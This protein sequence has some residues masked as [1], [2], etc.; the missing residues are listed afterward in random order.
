MPTIEQIRAA[1]ALL[2]W[3][4]HELADKA[5]LSQTGIARI[6]NG[7]NK[8]NSKTL[9]KIRSAF[10]EADIDF[11][12]DSGVKKRTGEVRILK[13]QEGFRSL[14]DDIYETASTLGGDI[15]LFNGTPSNF[16]QQLGEDWYNMHS[17]RM[18]ALKTDFTLKIIVKEGDQLLIASD[19]AEYKW[20]PEGLF[21]DKVFYSYGKKLALMNLDETPYISVIEQQDFAES[22]KVLFNIAWQHV[23]I[24]PPKN[25]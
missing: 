3:N 7:T 24:S 14:M 8:P 10:D 25:S 11:I 19:F 18:S 22:F 17:K 9:E 1:R 2:G 5:G 12:S 4:Q 16:L 13:G 23:A 20:F 21:K 6:E 15:C